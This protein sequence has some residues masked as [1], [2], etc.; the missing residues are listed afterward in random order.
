MSDGNATARELKVA[1]IVKMVLA[2]E[3]GEAAASQV[4]PPRRV[5][6]AAAWV[7]LAQGLMIAADHAEFLADHF[8]DPPP[9]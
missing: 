9:A 5:G 4:R 2:L 6:L 3:G 8:T 1:R 7:G